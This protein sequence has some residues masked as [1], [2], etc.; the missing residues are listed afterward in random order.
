MAP[1]RKTDVMPVSN[2][3]VCLVLSSLFGALAGAGAA[4]AILPEILKNR[5]TE[6]NSHKIRSAEFTSLKIGSA[7]GGSIFIGT[8]DKHPFVAL[9][10]KTG[11]TK[12]TL[13]LD[14]AD[15]GIVL[16][17][18]TKAT[19]TLGEIP[20]GEKRAT[21]LPLTTDNSA[22]RVMLSLNGNDGAISMAGNSNGIAAYGK[23]NKPQF[24]LTASD[25]SN[26]LSL[27]DM[28]GR[29]RL[30]VGNTEIRNAK[31]GTTTISAVSSITLFA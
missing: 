4:C 23:D 26:S 20:W 15:E 13:A 19:I 7:G 28:E 29:P 21:G 14:H 27:Y 2:L 25:N 22:H 11:K 9:N 3:V 10:D 31:T 12:L 8:A 6:L 30:V 18:N 17:S 1:H 5:P 16:L 24:Q